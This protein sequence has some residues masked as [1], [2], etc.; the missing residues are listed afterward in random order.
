MQPTSNPSS[1]PQ[2]PGHSNGVAPNNQAS[3]Q[4][5]SNTGLP[6]KKQRN[7]K[8]QIILLAVFVSIVVAVGVYFVFFS[9]AGTVMTGSNGEF[10]PLTPARILD[11][12]SGTNVGG[13]S[14]F[15]SQTTNTVTVLGQGGVP[16]T[17]VKAVV[18]NVTVVNPTVASYLTVWQS[19]T[20]RPLASSLNFVAGQVLSN[21]VTV[22]VASDGTVQAYNNTGTVDVIFDVVGYF[23][24]TEGNP[25]S[26]YVA[27]NP[28]RIVDTRGAVGGTTLTPT[29]TANVQI[30]GNG[31]V[32]GAGVRAVVMNV[33]VVNPT[34]AG[35]LT[36][37]PAGTTKPNASSINF[38]ANQVLSNQVTVPVGAEGKVNMFNYAG[39][40]NV[41]YDVVGYYEDVAP[42]YDQTQAGRYDTVTPTRILDTRSS[43]GTKSTG[44]NGTIGGLGTLTTN[45]TAAFKI[46]GKGGVPTSD[47]RAVT[48]NVT[49]VNP[50][51][52][53]FLTIWPVGLDRPGASSINF[54]AGQTLSNQITVPVDE[55]G[56]VQIYNSA[57]NTNV[58]FDVLGYYADYPASVSVIQGA[59]VNNQF[60][61]DSNEVNACGTKTISANISYQSAGSDYRLSYSP[62]LGVTTGATYGLNFSGFGAEPIQINFLAS[63]VSIACGADN[64]ISTLY[65]ILSAYQT[66]CVSLSQTSSIDSYNTEAGTR[67]IYNYAL[68][69]RP[70]NFKIIT[71]LLTN[72]D[73]AP[74]TWVKYSLANPDSPAVDLLRYKI[75]DTNLTTV[76]LG[77]T[78]MNVY[79]TAKCTSTSGDSLKVYNIM[80]NDR[81]VPITETYT[82]G[83][84]SN[85]VDIR[86]SSTTA[87]PGVSKTQL[88]K[89]SE[90][91]EGY[92]DWGIV[93]KNN[94]PKDQ[95]DTTKPVISDTQAVNFSGYGTLSYWDPINQTFTNSSLKTLT[96]YLASAKASDDNI[97]TVFDGYVDKTDIYLRGKECLDNATI[98]FIKSTQGKTLPS[99]D[100]VWRNQGKV[101]YD[102]FNITSIPYAPIRLMARDNSGNEATLMY[103]PKY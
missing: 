5:T 49:V 40:T 50:S 9:R 3:H 63:K 11:T 12:R 64:F 78:N 43:S 28:D 90:L 25:G 10:T 74:G 62:G 56:N 82:K 7:K 22:P 20:S 60:N 23:A 69:V 97:V 94:I 19:G 91:Y 14:T 93:F 29:Q 98:D 16:R 84:T 47:V 35:Y 58:I 76:Y 85:L 59:F 6:L 77:G 86:N 96:T 4:H 52:P 101:L 2:G 89:G 33:T 54:A 68:P 46:N 32:P 8:L 30:A 100:Q 102:V 36:I 1:N 17:G 42:G 73:N 44:T 51:A 80:S 61:C 67:K 83:D 15:G 24:N 75:A 57:G 66:S 70:G 71:S 41:I 34:T 27:I 38:S 18:M 95:R 92:T 99:C 45:Q 87:C 88:A 53:G 72:V 31:S 81:L 79:S 103:T 55:A 48:M 37:W 21:Q 39:N 26:R 65:E 13:L